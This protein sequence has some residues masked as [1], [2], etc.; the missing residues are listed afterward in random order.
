ML[1][2]VPF[3]RAHEIAG[4]CVRAAEQ[5]GVELD[6]L[7]AEDLSAIADELTPEVL[8]V[9]DVDGALASRTTRGGTAPEMVR[10]QVAELG[11]EIDA[12]RSGR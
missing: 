2:Q 9:L 8:Q 4:A 1:R 5:R 11:V 3:R 10:R 7:S 12:L 6:Q